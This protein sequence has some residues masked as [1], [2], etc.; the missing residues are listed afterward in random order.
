MSGRSETASPGANYQSGRSIID[1]SLYWRPTGF[2]SAI[3]VADALVWE[4]ADES[5]LRLVNRVDQF[6]Q[7]F[8]RALILR[9]IAD[10]HFRSGKPPRPDSDD[11]YLPAVELACRLAEA[12]ACASN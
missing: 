6:T 8:L 2:A 4:G 1:L 7:L 9:I 5:I 10:R 11:P 12:R 3:V